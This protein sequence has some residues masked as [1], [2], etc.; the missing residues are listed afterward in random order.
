M[1]KVSIIMP[2]YNK[3]KYIEKAVQSILHQTLQ[4][5]ELLI[6]DDGSTDASFEKCKNFNDTR[7][8]LIRVA[9]GGV[10]RARNI[11]L[12]IARGEYVTFI[13]G[14]DYV[15]KDYLH[16]LCV[17]DEDIIIG[18]LTK[19]NLL[20]VPLEE[21]LP[22]QRGCQTIQKVAKSFYE[23]QLTSGVYGFVA[24]KMIRRDIIEKNFLRFDE[25]IRLSE[26]Y[27]FFLK[28]YKEVSHIMFL[29][30]VG[31]YYVQETENSGISQD[32]TKIDFFIQ[33]EIQNSA[34][35]FLEKYQCFGGAAEEMYL[36]RVTGYVYTILQLNQDV[37]YTEFISLY[38]KLKNYVPAIVN[39]IRGIGGWYIFF[40]KNGW[41]IELFVL[42]KIHR[43]VRKLWQGL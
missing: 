1:C 9:N 7:I 17:H 13:D 41:Y 35:A 16:T 42:L 4:E 37:K 23:E 21:V 39:D 15:A 11:G 6:I 27:A 2:V 20:G 5:W 32:D 25:R 40:Y 3:E 10:S 28:I 24:G 29:D 36:K 22:I 14:D 30:N 34:K 38:K 12:N 18:G 19:V 43:V 8:K 33:I 31:Y 26:D